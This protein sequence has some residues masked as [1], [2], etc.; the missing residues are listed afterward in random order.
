[1]INITKNKPLTLISTAIVSC[2]LSSASFAHEEALE[3]QW[4]Q[5]GQI[6]I[7][8]QFQLHSKL[9]QTFMQESEV[10]SELKSCGQFD[11]D[12]TGARAAAHGTCAMYTVAS[13]TYGDHGTIRPIFTA[14]TSIKNDFSAHHDLYSID[15]GVSFSCGYCDMSEVVTR[16]DSATR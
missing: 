16:R 10:C 9:L 3:S 8:G 11:D 7:L 12:F 6:S 13:K 5:G 14:P 2:V 4:C 1:M 15:Q